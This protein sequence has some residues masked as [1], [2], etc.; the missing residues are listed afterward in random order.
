MARWLV[1]AALI[2]LEKQRDVTNTP[3]FPPI[4]NNNEPSELSLYDPAGANSAHH[5]EETLFDP[6]RDI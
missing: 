1:K 5:Q 2:A 3:P 6:I 4:V